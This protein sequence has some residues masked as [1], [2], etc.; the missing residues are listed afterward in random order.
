LEGS[1]G[2]PFAGLLRF[3][4]VCGW[5]LNNISPIFYVVLIL[6]HS[7]THLSNFIT[8]NYSTHYHKADI[9]T[10]RSSSLQTIPINHQ[11]LGNLLFVCLTF[12]KKYVSCSSSILLV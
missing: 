3:S 7:E 8:G 11:G 1:E 4:L 9:T 2:T 5:V 12:S 10:E 6:W